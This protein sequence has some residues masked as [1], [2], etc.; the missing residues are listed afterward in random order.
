MSYG[1][2]I[3]AYD[4]GQ[5]TVTK[6]SFP[7]EAAKVIA[8]YHA[9]DGQPLEVRVREHMQ[10]GVAAAASLLSTLSGEQFT[11][12][13]TGHVHSDVASDSL[14]WQSVQVTAKA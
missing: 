8:D 10:A 4:P 6:D 3:P 11:V 1:I 5:G 13:I 7:A 9:Y 2:S 14:D 12:S